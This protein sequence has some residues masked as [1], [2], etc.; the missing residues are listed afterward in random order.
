MKEEP[1]GM[2]LSLSIKE[3]QGTLANF[4]IEENDP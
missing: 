1:I 3:G 4:I 2:S